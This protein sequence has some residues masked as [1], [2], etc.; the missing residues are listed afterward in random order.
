MIATID[1]R[2]IDFG[3]W[4]AD[5]NFVHLHDDKERAAEANFV[6]LTNQITWVQITIRDDACEGCFERR[7][8]QQHIEFAELLA[9]DLG[10][11]LRGSQF[12]LCG[13]L[14]SSGDIHISVGGIDRRLHRRHFCQRI[15]SS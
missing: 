5:A 6:G 4:K 8:V 2:C 7:V 15:Q 13:R 14:L 1:E 3:N 11:R 9:G 12:G 10:L